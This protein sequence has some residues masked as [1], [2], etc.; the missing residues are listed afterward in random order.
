MADKADDEYISGKKVGVRESPDFYCT[1]A[2]MGLPVAAVYVTIKTSIATTS[3]H[4]KRAC[5]FLCVFF[6]DIITR[7]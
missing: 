2:H 6:T 5:C 3:A 4:G 1:S 7:K